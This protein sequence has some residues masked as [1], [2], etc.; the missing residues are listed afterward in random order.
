M[1]CGS[2]PCKKVVYTCGPRYNVQYKTAA[3]NALHFC[4]RNSLRF[5]KEEGLRT[6]VITCIYS[7]RKVGEQQERTQLLLRIHGL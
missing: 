7:K 2:L 6:M 3:E 5:L 4:Y 1:E